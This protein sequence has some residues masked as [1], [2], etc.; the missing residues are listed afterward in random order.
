MQLS[1]NPG[2]ET[3]EDVHKRKAIYIEVEKG[4]SI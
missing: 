2:I 1:S 3:K 4:T